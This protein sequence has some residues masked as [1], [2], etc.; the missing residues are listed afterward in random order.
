METVSGHL[1]S[2]ALYHRLP[3]LAPHL[4]PLLAL[5]S[6]PRAVEVPVLIELVVLLQLPLAGVLFPEWLITAFNLIG[7]LMVSLLAVVM[8]ITATLV[9]VVLQLL[10]LSL[11][12]T[13][14]VGE[15]EP[16]QCVVIVK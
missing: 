16:T 11:L 5:L 9:L 12:D 7:V 6:L 4:L 3:P 2:T 14:T 13:P 1:S 15:F 10:A 8:E